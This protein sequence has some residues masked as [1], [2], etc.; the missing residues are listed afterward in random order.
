M[1]KL[2][3]KYT[4]RGIA[5]DQVAELET[6]SRYQDAI[7]LFNQGIKHLAVRNSPI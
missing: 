4:E 3:G 1:E 2:R 6:L 7:N 5:E